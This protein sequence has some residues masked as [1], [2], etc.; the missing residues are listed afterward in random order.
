MPAARENNYIHS[1]IPFRSKPHIYLSPICNDPK[2]PSLY[3]LIAIPYCSVNCR[4]QHQ[5][6]KKKK[7]FTISPDTIKPKKKTNLNESPQVRAWYVIFFFIV[8]FPTGY[9]ARNATNIM[10]GLEEGGCNLIS[11]SCLTLHKVRFSFQLVVI[12]HTCK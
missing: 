4:S 11:N 12:I 6:S 7:I 1:F 2:A 10:G 5:S 9:V 3:L 8:N